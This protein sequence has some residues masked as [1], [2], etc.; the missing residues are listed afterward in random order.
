[1]IKVNLLRDQTARV[2]KTI[3]RPTASRMGLTFLAIFLLAAG[4]VGGWCYYVSQQVSTLMGTRNKLR[5]EEARLQALQKEIERYD[6]LKRLRQNRIDLIEKLKE[7]QKGPVLLLNSVIQSI[8]H[9]GVIWLTALEQKEDRVKIAGRT[10]RPEDIPDFLSN[11]AE[12]GIFQSVDLELIEN[13][14]DVSKF[15]LL[16]ISAVKQQG[17]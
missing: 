4:G 8:P 9:D 13:E 5:S 14:K 16:C 2:R 15:S 12:T 11:L 6:N 1:M 17:E 10:Q 3:S 7:S